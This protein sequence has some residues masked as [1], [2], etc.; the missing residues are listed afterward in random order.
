MSAERPLRTGFTAEQHRVRTC[1]YFT[2]P[3]G[4]GEGAICGS[5]WLIFCVRQKSDMNRIRVGVW[6]SSRDVPAMRDV[7]HAGMP[8]TGV[9][10]L[11]FQPLRWYY[12]TLVDCHGSER[13]L[14]ERNNALVSCWC[15]HCA[16]L[17]DCRNLI[18]ALVLLQTLLWMLAC[19]LPSALTRTCPRHTS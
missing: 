4:E 6:S 2:N 14:D 18:P 3:R 15:Q 17:T 10:A 8:L 12:T 7:V 11:I 1:N 16:W 5:A 9:A 19:R 13:A